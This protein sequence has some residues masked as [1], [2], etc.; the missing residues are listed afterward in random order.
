[1]ESILLTLALA[2]CAEDPRYCTFTDKG[3]EVVIT[4]CNLAPEDEGRPIT[5]EGRIK[6][7]N[8]LVVLEP[9]CQSL[10]VGTMPVSKCS[11]GK[12]K[13]GSGKCMYTTKTA[14]ERAQKAYKAKQSK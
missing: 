3:T 1:M 4:A 6:G 7:K 13:I 10:W 8:Y 2:T 5:L 14:A 11:N 9:K 12:Y